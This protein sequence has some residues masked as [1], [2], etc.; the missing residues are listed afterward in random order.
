MQ[1]VPSLQSLMAVEGKINSFIHC[2]VETWTIASL[3]DLERAI[4]ENEGI[5]RFEELALGP[6]LR[7][8]LVTQYFSLNSDVTEVFKI[9][10]GQI[11]WYLG[12]FLSEHNSREGVEIGDLLSFIAKE[13]SVSEVEKLGVRIQS[14]GCH[15]S[16]ILH[17]KRSEATCL[18]RYLNLS[19][20]DEDDDDLL[21]EYNKPDDDCNRDEKSGQDMLV[22]VSVSSQRFE[23][24]NLTHA[25]WLK[26][27]MEER[28][29]FLMD[30]T[31]FT[32]KGRKK[33]GA[34]LVLETSAMR[35]F[36]KDWKEA[37]RACSLPM[38]S[39]WFSFLDIIDAI[40]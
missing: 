32:K 11:V 38:V 22:H 12:K 25:E 4:C 34:R 29:K 18:R 28:D 31:N 15:I 24:E 17:A 2:F 35:I 33:K 1:Q 39:S 5:E 37:C 16:F 40:K 9:T 19:S 30:R 3:Y 7:H 36:M 20:D 14:L 8:P 6:F 13:K 10:S 26:R 27:D 23:S 21:N